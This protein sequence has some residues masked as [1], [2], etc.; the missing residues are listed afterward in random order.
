MT[1]TAP[2]LRDLVI[3]ALAVAILCAVHEIAPHVAVLLG[4]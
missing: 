3:C 1:F 2:A 4:D